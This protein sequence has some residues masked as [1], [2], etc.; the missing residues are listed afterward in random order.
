MEGGGAKASNAAARRVHGGL[1]VPP[2][3]RSND[4]RLHVSGAGKDEPDTTDM[5]LEDSA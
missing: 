3:R 1:G 4:A 2:R 5:I